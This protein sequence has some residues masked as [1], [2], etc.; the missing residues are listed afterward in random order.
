MT[1]REKD[2]VTTTPLAPNL[3]HYVL[4]NL[5]KEELKPYSIASLTEDNKEQC[6]MTGRPRNT[7]IILNTHII[8]D[9]G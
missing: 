8:K 2:M 3:R 5:V 1:D 7:T 6:R 4:R 9:Q